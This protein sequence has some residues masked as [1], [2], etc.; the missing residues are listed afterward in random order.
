V[1]GEMQNKQFMQTKTLVQL[2]V[3]SSLNFDFHA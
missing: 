3:G 1:K 2:S